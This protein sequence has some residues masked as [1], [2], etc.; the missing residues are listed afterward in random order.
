MVGENLALGSQESVPHENGVSKKYLAALTLGALGVVFGDI[1]TSPLYALRECFFGSHSISLTPPH[2]LGVLSLIVWSL[3]ILISIDYLLFILSADNKGEGGVFA[4][5]ALISKQKGR[6]SAVSMK[7]ILFTGI[8]GAALLYGDGMIT[9]AISV[10]SAVEGFEIL[11]PGVHD[12]ISLIAIVILS[13]L[14]AVQSRG[15]AKVGAVFGPII[16]LWFAALAILGIKG[17]ITEPSVLKA[18]NPIYGLEFLIE[19]KLQSI[20]ILGSVFL[21][22]TG[23]EALYADMGHFGKLPIR[24]GWFSVVLPALI[25]NYLGQGALLLGDPSKIIREN[26]FFSLSPSWALLP[27]VILATMATVIASQALIAGAFSLTR[28]AVQLGY[29][30]RMEIRHTSS[31][32]IGQIYVPVVNWLLLLANI[33]LV[34]TFKSS[35]NLAAAYG[36]A[37]STSMVITT[38]L[39]YFVARDVWR[40]RMFIPTIGWIG[41]FLIKIGFFSA[42]VIKIP[43]GGWFPLVV[44]SGI[45]ILMTTWWRGRQIVAERLRSRSSPLLEFIASIKAKP[46]LRVPGISIFL[47]RSSEGTPTAL[48]HNLTHNKVLHEK[49]VILTIDTEDEPTVPIQDRLKIENLDF[50]IYRAVARYGFME[51]PHVPRLMLL[52][53]DQGLKVD[54]SEATFFLGRET[55]IPT[56]REGMALWREGLFAFMA[57]NAQRAMNFFKIPADRVVEI[58]VQVEL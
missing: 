5:L 24:I 9:P 43:Y 4:L 25:L 45:M 11:V 49:V 50:G 47:A 44:G 14:F 29:L 15:T 40:W 16:L 46:P 21:V 42:A 18:L 48:I 41:I 10:L 27:M 56:H 51:T 22:V 26:P 35:G 32:E 3:I 38:I 13:S 57:R 30:P 36:F 31:D 19:T 58:G 20:W 52:C 23:G 55:L 39:M 17:I 54:P 53:Q 12:Y 33:W 6:A 34:L 2:V 7:L 37:V 8:A 1:G 28:Q